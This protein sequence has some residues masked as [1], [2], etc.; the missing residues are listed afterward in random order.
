ME[1]NVCYQAGATYPDGVQLEYDIDW[2][3]RNLATPNIGPREVNPGLSVISAQTVRFS[4]ATGYTLTFKSY[5]QGS[6]PTL[7][8]TIALTESPAG[9]G[10]YNTIT[11]ITLGTPINFTI[12]DST[13][14]I[15]GQG[16]M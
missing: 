7:V 1:G 11:A 15:V 9:S 16:V 6:S 3:P 14:T 4:Y 8:Q 2:N 12:T 10:V 5:T 13:G